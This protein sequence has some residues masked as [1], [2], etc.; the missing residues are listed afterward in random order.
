[1][2]TKLTWNS[3]LEARNSLWA[4]AE[5]LWERRTRRYHPPRRRRRRTP[6]EILAWQ[7]RKR[8]QLRRAQPFVARHRGGAGRARVRRFVTLPFLLTDSSQSS[9]VK[10]LRPGTGDVAGRLVA[11]VGGGRRRAGP[12]GGCRFWRLCGGRKSGG[13]CGGAGRRQRGDEGS[14]REGRVRLRRQRA[15]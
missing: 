1:M 6:P 9:E 10:K 14:G 15:S 4:E 11:A 3:G 2:G 7:R 8:M 13:C 12:G 5:T